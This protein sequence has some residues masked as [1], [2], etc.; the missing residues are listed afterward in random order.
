MQVANEQKNR[1]V[2]HGNSGAQKVILGHRVRKL[3]NSR[4]LKKKGLVKH[5][6]RGHIL[7]EA[8]EAQGM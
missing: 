4:V 8:H 3:R 1:D 6:V 7:Q 2:M 5:E